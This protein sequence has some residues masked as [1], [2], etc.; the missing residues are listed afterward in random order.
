MILER[1]DV[2]PK[3]LNLIKALHD[4]VFAEVRVNGELTEGFEL[5]MGVKQGGVLSGFFWSIYMTVIIEE[6]NKRFKSSKV[7]GILVKYNINGNVV[8]LNNLLD[9]KCNERQ[10]FEIIFVDN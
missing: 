7:K 3:L 8:N 10:I 1:R 2:P 4:G 9:N 6:T 5:K